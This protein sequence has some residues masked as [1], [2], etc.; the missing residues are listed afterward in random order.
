MYFGE[1]IEYAP[2][3]ELFGSPQMELTRNYL[4]GNFG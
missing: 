3:E 1:V 4:E 2:T